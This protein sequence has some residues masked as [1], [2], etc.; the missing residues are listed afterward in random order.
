MVDIIKTKFGIANYYSNP[1][2]IEVNEVLFEPEFNLL[3]NKIVQHELEHHRAKDKGF[4]K[5]REIDMK[6]ELKFSDL[7]PVYKKK[8]SLFFQQMSPIVYLDKTIYF[9]WSLIILY[10]LG[11]GILC[12][13]YLLIRAFS[14]DNIL[15]WKIIK[16]MA[17]LFPIIIILYFLGKKATKYVNKQ[18]GKLK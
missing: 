9:E 5:Q 8:P 14:T 7:L 6:T 2:R 4:F 18:A 3:L 11:I 17:I 13:I 1:E 12:G 16:N 10:L 15:F